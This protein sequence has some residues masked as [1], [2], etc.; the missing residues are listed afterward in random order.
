MEGG[1]MTDLD[2]SQQASLTAF[3]I[4]AQQKKKITGTTLGIRDTAR[5]A[6]DLAKEEYLMN[7]N[8]KIGVVP[9]TEPKN[10]ARRFAVVEENP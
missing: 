2:V 5:A 6:I 9:Y 7:M 10:G 1:I 8:R 4:P 3:G